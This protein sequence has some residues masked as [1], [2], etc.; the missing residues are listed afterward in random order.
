MRFTFSVFW[1]EHTGEVYALRVP[2]PTAMVHDG[3]GDYGFGGAAF[4]PAT[5]EVLGWARTRQ[6]LDARLGDRHTKISDPD[7]I[8]WIRSQLGTP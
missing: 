4:A 8:G 1:L 7:G 2:N 6:E 5:V 3:A